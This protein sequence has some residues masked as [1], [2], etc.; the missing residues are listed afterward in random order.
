MFRLL[1]LVSCAAISLGFI[2]EFDLFEKDIS[3]FLFPVVAVCVSALKCD[4]HE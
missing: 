3:F 1:T 2:G 4:T